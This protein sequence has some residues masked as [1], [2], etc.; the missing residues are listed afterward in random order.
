M[1]RLACSIR[2][3]L[4]STVAIVGS[5]GRITVPSPWLPGKIGTEATIVVERWGA[6]TESIDV[7]LDADVYTVEVDAVHTSIRAGQ[8]SAATMP[9]EDSLANMRTLDRWRAAVGLRFADDGSS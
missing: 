7:P 1:A 8:R 3:N 9:W 2:A 6:E 5:E 4:V